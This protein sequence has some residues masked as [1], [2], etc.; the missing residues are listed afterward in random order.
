[1]HQTLLLVLAIYLYVCSAG[2]VEEPNGD[3]ENSV[4]FGGAGYRRVAVPP[5]LN[6]AGDEV[7]PGIPSHNRL[8]DGDHPF[9]APGPGD[10]RGPCHSP[11]L[12]E[13]VQYES[14]VRFCLDWV[15]N[16]QLSVP[17]PLILRLKCCQGVPSSLVP[18]LPNG[19]KRYQRHRNTWSYGRGCFSHQRSVSS[20]RERRLKD[21]GPQGSAR[22]AEG[23]TRTGRDYRRKSDDDNDYPLEIVQECGDDDPIIGTHSL[24]SIKVISNSSA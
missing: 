17:V 18:P 22:D 9:K 7:F 12:R 10:Q 8:S 21:G 24:V 3:D 6:P 1:M 5:P 2:P 15:R 19:C 16:G 20:T 13:T 4:L 23:R 11:S 14:N